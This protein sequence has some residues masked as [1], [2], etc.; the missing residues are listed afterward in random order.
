MF[1]KYQ[2]TFYKAKE[3]TE[4][5]INTPTKYIIENSSNILIAVMSAIL[6]T[7]IAK[8]AYEAGKEDSRKREGNILWLVKVDLKI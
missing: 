4:Q 1:K 2:E 6:T 3:K 7:L 5:V 8:G